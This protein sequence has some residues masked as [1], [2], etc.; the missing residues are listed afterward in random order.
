MRK[1]ALLIPALFLIPSCFASG[2]ASHEAQL[3]L[4]NE[5]ID[6]IKIGDKITVEPKTLVYE[7]QSKTVEGQILLPDGTSQS[8]KSF[9]IEMPGIY[10]VNYRAFFGT[11]E[12]SISLFY[13]CHR[14]SGDFFI[15]SN[16]DNPAQS[17]EYSHPIYNGEIKGAKLILDS[18][19]TFTYDGIIDFSSYDFSNSFIDFVVD[20]SKQGTSDIETFTVRLTDTEDSS[21]FVDITV[22]DSGPVDDAGRGCYMLAGSS[23]QFKTGYEGG[24]NGRLHISKYGANVGSS[25]R[26]LPE[27]S[28]KVAKLYFN[29]NEKEIHVS[30]HIYSG[31]KDIITDLDDK[32]IYGS[33]IWEG[34][35]N[36]KAK[37]SIFANSMLSNNATLIVSKIANYDLSPLDFVDV[38]APVIKINYAGQSSISVPKASIGKPYKIYEAEVSDNFDRNLSYS[39]YV[40]YYDASKGKNRDITIN[41]GYFTPKDEGVYTINYIAKDHSNNYTTKTVE[42]TAISDGQA[43]TIS[44]D[45]DKIT[46]DLYSL[47]KL[48]SIED[49]KGMITGGS[50]KPVVERMIYDSEGREITINGDSFTPDKIGEYKVYYKAKDYINNVSTALLKV[51]V[52]DP[53]H[54]VFIDEFNFPRILIKGHTYTLP[55]YKGAEVDNG[56][57]VYLDSKVFVNNEELIDNTF[58]AGDNCKIE[59]KLNGKTG[60]IIEEETITVID[61]GYPIDLAKY[62]VGNFVPEV[63]KNDITLSTSNNGNEAHALFASVL[64]YNS[65]YLK[66]GI[67]RDDFNCD[68]LVF[69]FT[70]STNKNNS[71]SFHFKIKNDTPYI[72][73]GADETEYVF[74]SFEE[75]VENFAI[76]L[77]TSNMVLKDILHKDVAVVKYND[78]GEVFKGFN[79]GIYLDITMNNIKANSK[80]KMLTISNQAL[81]NIGMSQYFDFIDP[82]IILKENFVTE[83]EYN[84]NAFIP[85]AE[86]YDV[87]SY[88]DVKISVRAPDGTY[89]IRDKD[90]K[91]RHSFVLDQ[92][93]KFIVTYTGTDTEGNA[94]IYRRSITVYDFVPPELTINGGL[95]SIYSIN[96]AITIPSYTVSDNLGSYT[97]DVFLIL[98]DGQERLLLM[99]K[100]GTVT[101]YLNK[102]NMY[103]NASFK[104]NDTTFRAEQ[105]GHY[106]L[107]YVAYD[108]DFNKVTKELSF[109]VK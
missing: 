6:N 97:V 99:D 50:G 19:T 88:A 60:S 101:S 2:Q 96:S 8:G 86:V 47:V 87:L 85:I 23:S 102:D 9:T 51:N 12:E 93:G 62:F 30:P 58:V 75:E 82:I 95:A 55:Q 100:N 107:R 16:K 79:G 27:K 10:T 81:G 52:T 5:T 1:K 80:L 11:H 98:P 15:S 103:Y 38:D 56:K 54:P 91:D 71:L 37:L 42:V 89:K 43:M 32:S 4:K 74:S 106:I 83:Q 68:N 36:G 44:L 49:V 14:T 66:F 22:T 39:T 3:L 7:G 64:S 65:L 17:G 104:V 108:S 46:Q 94:A 45:K 67:N 33:A 78:Q 31:I 13:H 73:V 61:V 40:T 53:G 109:D 25:F 57:T 28:A 24:R 29:Y 69:K 35:T 70:D 90:A 34:F 59:Y 84:A 77:S 48:P 20:T 76:D 21:N 105:Y 18:K 63:N 41:D 26:D 72:S 92:F